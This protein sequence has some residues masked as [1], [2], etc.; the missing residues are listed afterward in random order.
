M[1]MELPP[2][3]GNSGDREPIAKPFCKVTIFGLGWM[4]E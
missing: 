3:S 1:V 4:R 2:I